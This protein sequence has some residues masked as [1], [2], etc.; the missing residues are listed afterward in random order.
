MH[1]TYPIEGEYREPFIA[2]TKTE[3]GWLAEWGIGF[4]NYGSVH[5]KSEDKAVA[6]AKKRM[7]R[8]WDRYQRRMIAERY[9]LDGLEAL[10]GE[11]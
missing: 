11:R 5:K 10:G 6:I 7:A 8:D 9:R 3:T 2:V 4:L 1:T